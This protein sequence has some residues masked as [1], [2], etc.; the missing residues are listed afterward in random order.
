[1][2]AGGWLVLPS[3]VQPKFHPGWWRYFFFP[4]HL[5]WRSIS[6][7]YKSFPGT[8]SPHY[9]WSRASPPSSR[10]T[11]LPASVSFSNPPACHFSVQLFPQRYVSSPPVPSAVA[12]SSSRPPTFCSAAVPQGL[13]LV[14]RPLPRNASLTSLPEGPLCY[15]TRGSRFLHC[16]MCPFAY[17]WACHVFA[18]S[19]G[20]QDGNEQDMI[21]T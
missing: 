19:L 1:M 7:V 6:D 13:L 18:W 10:L 21:E 20:S 11:T 2:G 8:R 14:S 17:F 5:C 9:Q 3:Q 12:R 15:L 4:P 16:H